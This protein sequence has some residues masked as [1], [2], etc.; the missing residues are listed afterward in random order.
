MSATNYVFFKEKTQNVLKRKNMYFDEKF[1]EICIFIWACLLN[2]D[3]C[4]LKSSTEENI[5]PG[6]DRRISFFWVMQLLV[7]FMPS[8]IAKNKK[9]ALLFFVKIIFY[10][11]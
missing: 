5:Y 10:L 11:C 1:G 3:L 9:I 2:K 7:F 8:L 4:K 6:I